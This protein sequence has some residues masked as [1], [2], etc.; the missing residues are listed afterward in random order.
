MEVSMLR[1]LKVLVL[2]G[3][4]SITGAVAVAAGAWVLVTVGPHSLVTPFLVLGL[5]SIL[6]VSLAIADNLVPRDNLCVRPSVACPHCGAP[7]SSGRV[8]KHD[9]NLFGYFV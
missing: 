4:F 9:P 5:A 7:S 2:W 8:Q 1:F 3:M 6:P